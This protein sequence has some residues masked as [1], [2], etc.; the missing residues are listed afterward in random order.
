MIEQEIKK[1]T[2][3]YTPEWNYDPGAPDVGG[4]VAKVFM[5]MMK[6]SAKKFDQLSLKNRIAFLNELGADLLPSVCADG[7]VQFHYLSFRCGERGRFILYFV[8]R[9]RI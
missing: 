9:W 4:A 2:E 7:Y 3:S 5:Q 8:T 6:R 1:R